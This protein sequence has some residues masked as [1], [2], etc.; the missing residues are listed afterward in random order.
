MFSPG[1]KG[2]PTGAEN[3][4]A[5]GSLGSG[6]HFCSL[7]LVDAYH[8]CNIADLFVLL[9]HLFVCCFV[10]FVLLL[11]LFVC[12][13]PW[14]RR[15]SAA[16]NV[17]RWEIIVCMLHLIVWNLGTHWP[18]HCIRYRQIRVHPI[19]HKSQP[20]RLPI[21]GPKV[22]KRTWFY[23]CGLW[24]PWHGLSFREKEGLDADLIRGSRRPVPVVRIFFSAF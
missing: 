4:F 7:G 9:L 1:N 6:G 19:M 12:L 24:K 22:W 18:L 3:M 17:G 10:F 11:H 21:F 15:P 2:A 5:K 13:K 20:A 8:I 16:V 23:W 14:V